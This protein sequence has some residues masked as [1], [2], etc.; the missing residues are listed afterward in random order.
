MKK[1]TIYIWLLASFT[2]AQIK[3]ISNSGSPVLYSY[4]KSLGS[5]VKGT[6]YYDSLLF[7]G[8]R[9]P[10]YINSVDTSSRLNYDNEL[11]DT[12]AS[13]YEGSS[14][15]NWAAYG[16]NTV[17]NTGNELVITYV[18]NSSGASLDVSSVL[19]RSLITDNTYTISFDAKVNSGSNIEI[20]FYDT[21]TLIL[22]KELT[23]TSYQRISKTFKMIDDTFYVS[24]GGSFGTGEILYLDNMSLTLDITKV[25]LNTNYYA[26]FNADVSTVG[27]FTDTLTLNSTAKNNSKN[28]L[29][30]WTVYADEPSGSPN[31]PTLL[32][33]T[34]STDTDNGMGLNWADNTELDLA[35]YIVEKS[36]NGSDFEQADIA[37]TS[38][39][40]DANIIEALRYYYRVAAVDQDGNISSYSS[41]VNAKSLTKASKWTTVIYIDSNASAGGNGSYLTP[42]NSTSSVTFTALS[43]GTKIMFKGGY[44]YF[45]QLNFN[46]ANGTSSSPIVL[47]SYG[48]QN[49]YKLRNSSY[50][51]TTFVT[52]ASSSNY[53]TI[54][55]AEIIGRKWLYGRTLSHLTIDNC[56]FKHYNNT[57]TDYTCPDGQP[58]VDL[59]YIDNAYLT[60][61]NS[62]LEGAFVSVGLYS[63]LVSVV[64]TSYYLF[65]NNYFRNVPHVL[66][67]T[68]SSSYGV[69]R[70]NRF[71]NLY[72]ANL[73][74]QGNA[75]NILLEN[76]YFEKAG[77]GIDDGTLTSLGDKTVGGLYLI[78]SQLIFRNNILKKHG[79]P[80]SVY[81]YLPGIDIISTYNVFL[82]YVVDSYNNRIYNNTIY[83]N[84]SVGMRM[85]LSDT[86]TKLENIKTF[87]N[88]FV[89]NGDL[90][91]KNYSIYEADSVQ[92]MLFDDNSSVAPSSNYFNYNYFGAALDNVYYQGEKDANEV[93]TNGFYF[94]NN[95]AGSYNVYEFG[96]D[97]IITPLSWTPTQAGISFWDS[98]KVKFNPNS[99]LQD[100]GQ[101]LTTVSS[102][103]S[104]STNL[105][106][107]D[108]R[109]FFSGHGW[110]Q[111]DSIVITKSS[112]KE[113]SRISSI[114]NST[115]TLT[116]ANAVTAS[117]GD[118][119]D[120]VN[121][122]QGEYNG[123]GVDIGAVEYYYIDTTPKAPQILAYNN[124]SVAD[125]S[126]RLQITFK[127]NYSNTTVQ[128]ILNTDSLEILNG[129]YSQGINPSE[130][131]GSGGNTI[132]YKIVTPVTQSVTYYYKW[133]LTNSI[134]STNSGVKSYV[135]SY[136][137]PD[138]SGLY[139]SNL[140]TGYNEGFES[141]NITNWTAQ[142]SPTTFE[143]SIEQVYVGTYS[144][145][146]TASAP[147][148]GA[149]AKYVTITAGKN[150][151]V[152]FKYYLTAGTLR[153][154]DY[155]ERLGIE[156]TYTTTGSWVEVQ[157][158]VTAN[159]SGICSLYFHTYNYWSA[160]TFYIDD[161]SIQEEL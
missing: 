156:T 25:N 105:I 122:I 29:I 83:D 112:S 46:N 130:I 47:T 70:N 132:S 72:H 33:I 1:L 113:Y 86:G 71:Y 28:V 126:M 5:I 129:N 85:W 32:A 52:D 152:S 13:T 40:L 57:N 140:L 158:V 106:V 157:T 34:D 96:S 73:N 44:Q 8:V 127:T 116:L 153:L 84:Y 77:I 42:Y 115:N 159:T 64:R 7:W 61:R 75:N 4:D 15:Y 124:T 37:Y 107:A 133:I 141:G 79:S 111:G 137:P 98:L 108:S 125:D 54:A 148:K 60:F 59:G 95:L 3:I 160:M 146:V 41:T 149:Y 128:L 6:T 92:I 48:S 9:K 161:V 58:P 18:D 30:T 31:A 27:T 50:S 22:L 103:V 154:T 150:Y 36:I 12:D 23:E 65:E 17:A 14:V 10:F 151:L 49:R 20:Y 120:V 110:L 39:Y 19:D 121:S 104:S 147:F 123:D 26:K 45:G 63:D 81:D 93:N 102:S 134:G 117:A 53:L 68:T 35:H 74:V 88:A 11:W 89:K 135:H 51:S 101:H 67:G 100:S 155:H 91:W 90:T 145:K 55:N 138:T 131:S 139:G 21:D 82:S 24:F 62:I 114:N 97:S 144:G 78:G 56:N 99:T 87:N 76:N 16:N 109:V 43:A 94:T 142:G 119:V 2:F 69:I 38:N 118:Y 80:R 66:L 143:A 136:V